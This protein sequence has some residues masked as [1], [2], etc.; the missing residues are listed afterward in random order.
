MRT[1]R[2]ERERFTIGGRHLRLDRDGRDD[3]AGQCN[4]D[5]R[6]NPGFGVAIRAQGLKLGDRLVVQQV[7]AA[8]GR[9][10]RQ[11]RNKNRQA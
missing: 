6:A 8:A 9:P 5:H 7:A 3:R 2:L 10:V 1:G 4:F 11:K